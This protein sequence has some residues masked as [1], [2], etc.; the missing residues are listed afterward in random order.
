MRG[1]VTTASCPVRRCA[2]RG[3]CIR[4]SPPPAVLATPETTAA[5]EASVPMPDGSRCAPPTASDVAAPAGVL[6]DRAPRPPPRRRPPIRSLRS[7]RPTGRSPSTCA[8]C[9]RKSDR[10][11]ANRKERTVVETFYQNRNLAPL[12]FDKGV[13][14]ARAK[15]AI[16]RM[17][18]A[19][20]DG[21][22]PKDYRFP[23]MTA[24]T[25]DAQ[26]EAELRLTATV[27]TFTRHLQAGRFPYQRI[28][29]EV[30]FPQTP[31]DP[32]AVLTMLADATD[33]GAA[34]R[35]VQPAAPGLS[36]AQRQARRVAQCDQHRRAHGRAHSGRRAAAARNGRRPRSA[37][38]PAAEG[39]RRR[40]HA[41]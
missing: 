36:G 17:E 1:P 24:A 39:R 29:G 38:A 9:C 22:D 16:A 8:T 7:I 6:A 31:P 18:K 41:L 10:I 40:Q 5:I 28:G 21:L 23:D 27:I 26:A 3:G 19:A 11:F 12:W 13:Q 25:P 30:M 2:S 35:R 15:A 4:A 33:A 37:A 20:A 14:N 32:A 34:D